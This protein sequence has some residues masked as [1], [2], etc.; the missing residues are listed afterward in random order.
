MSE[1]ALDSAP[2]LGPAPGLAQGPVLEPGLAQVEAVAMADLE[3]LALWARASEE[4]EVSAAV[5]VASCRSR[6][7][8]RTRQSARCSS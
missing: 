3:A 7:K 1:R 5:Q 6:G 8:Q 2:G 4:L